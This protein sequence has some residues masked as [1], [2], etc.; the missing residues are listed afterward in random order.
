MIEKWSLLSREFL[1][2]CTLYNKYLA[3]CGLTLPLPT[4]KSHLELF[5]YRHTFKTLLTRVENNQVYA[6]YSRTFLA[7]SFTKFYL[8]FVD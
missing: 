3:A 8:I 6:Q 4:S 1:T 2:F 5:R 7:V